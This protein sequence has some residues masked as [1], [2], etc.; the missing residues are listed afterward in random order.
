MASMTAVAVV[1][2]SLYGTCLFLVPKRWALIPLL[3]G[4]CYMTLGQGIEVGVFGFTVLRLLIVIGVLRVVVRGEGVSGSTCSMDHMMLAWVIWALV[5]SAFHHNFFPSLVY[6]VGIA[7]DCCGIYFLSRV[8][9]ESENDLIRV[10]RT[11]ALLLAP[12]AVEML[13]EK[14]TGHD[15]FSMLGGVG[16]SPEVRNGRIR[17]QGPF[18]HSILAGTVGGVCLPFMWAL[19]RQHPLHTFVGVCACIGIVLFSASSTPLLSI[20]AGIAALYSWRHR[21]HMR[22]IRWM[23]VAAYL[24]L[25]LVMKDPPYYLLARVDLAG[26]STGWFRAR[27]IQSSIQHLSE[28]WLAGTDYTRHWMAT[29][30]EWSEAQTDITNHYIKQGVLGGLLLMGLFIGLMAVAFQYV[31]RICLRL[32]P[33]EQ[34]EASMPWA[35]GASLFAYAAAG[36]AVSFFDQ[37]TFFLHLFLGC[38]ASVY[39]TSVRSQ[40][41]PLGSEP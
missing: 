30:V 11:V 21:R 38:I 39:A 19:R 28:W 22:E 36:F 9:C 31:G 25:S 5:S 23:I 10:A 2:L 1:F 3:T 7:G 14:L 4:A 29:G 35:L 37:S 26:G 13:F 8:F 6:R 20:G 15:M 33:K 40:A 34:K 32:R 17:A 24:F 27:L 16:A 18:A 41:T 12:I